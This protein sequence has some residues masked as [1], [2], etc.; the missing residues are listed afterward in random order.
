MPPR[1]RAMMTVPR[2]EPPSTYLT[3]T[4]S[5]RQGQSREALSEFRT[6]V[7]A[8]LL[9]TLR[10]AVDLDGH[11]SS[12]PSRITVWCSSGRTPLHVDLRRPVR[13]CP[14]PFPWFRRLRFLLRVRPYVPLRDRGF[15]MQLLHQSGRARS[16]SRC[17]KTG[18][19]LAACRVAVVEIR[20]RHVA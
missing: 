8:C 2:G 13:R 18:K 7:V 20:G 12:T 16:R 1:W 9:D 14:T 11:H 5:S 10:K 19:R 6:D 15:R 3:T 4:T 17:S